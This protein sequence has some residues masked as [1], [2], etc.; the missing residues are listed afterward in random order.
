MS[1][2]KIFNF[3]NPTDFTPL[4]ETANNILKPISEAL[5]GVFLFAFQKPIE[6]GIV[7]SID[8]EYL[9]EMTKAKYQKIHERN[10]TF[11]NVSAIGKIFSD[12]IY[13]LSSEQF[14]DLF[15]SLIV[16]SIDNRKS[17]K[18]FYSSLI[19][20]MS[21]DE[22]NLLNYF[23]K[24]EVLFEINL[25]SENP[26]TVNE[27][28]YFH[29]WEPKYFKLSDQI[30]NNAYKNYDSQ[31]WE[32]LYNNEDFYQDNIRESVLFLINHGIIE[33]T[34]PLK[35]WKK[36]LFSS[37]EKTVLNNDKQ[38]LALREK[39]SDTDIEVNISNK[40][41]KLSIVGESLKIILKDDF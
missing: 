31:N 41:Y 2:L 40:V 10:V 19:K 25:L 14:R 22:A 11:E 24:C 7:K 18:P 33:E 29:Y 20:E 3:D 12:S 37:L 26:Y 35:R 39:S 30:D 15:S 1:D 9:A 6:Y 23:F 32:D 28:P 8:L 34:L 21:S 16:A 38:V 27:D 13:Q 36:G 4:V 17:V 5:E